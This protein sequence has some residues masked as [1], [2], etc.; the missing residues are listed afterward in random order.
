MEQS[1]F[2]T[3]DTVFYEKANEKYCPK[4]WCWSNFRVLDSNMKCSLRRVAL[5]FHITN[6][7]G[8][9]VV[10]QPVKP[11]A[12]KMSTINVMHPARVQATP[13]FRSHFWLMGLGSSTGWCKHLGPCYQRGRARDSSW[14]LHSPWPS[15]DCCRCMG[16]ELMKEDI[17]L[18]SPKQHS[19]TEYI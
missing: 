7:S 19:F 15:P 18:Y 8:P 9:V 11:V 17:A 16:S 13:H 14:L 4:F 1:G 2:S 5:H 3:T 12:D 10:A 6:T